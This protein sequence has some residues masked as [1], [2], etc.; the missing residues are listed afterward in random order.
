MSPEATTIWQQLEYSGL[1][2]FIAE[3]TWAFPTIETL[4]VISLV[5]VLGTIF[6]VD[7]RMLGLTSN[8]FA[9]TRIARDTLPWTWG[10]FACAA[11]TGL[12]L[13][14]SKASSYVINP[15]FLLKLGMIVL[16]GLN[17]LYFHFVTWRSVDDWDRGAPVPTMV[18]VSG[19]LSLAFWILVVFFGRAIGFT[20]SMFY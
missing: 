1:G 8:K 10:A 14:V 5:T 18:R 7:L 20:L 9:I 19:A 4:H 17:M 11:V 3:S 16:A 13:F 2:T 12:L 15:Y 6:V